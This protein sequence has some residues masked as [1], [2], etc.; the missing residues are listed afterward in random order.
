MG[1]FLCGKLVKLNM[2]EFLISISC[3]FIC[4]VSITSCESDQDKIAKAQQVVNSFIADLNFENFDNIETNYPGFKKVRSFYKLNDFKVKSST[5]N[6]NEVI[7]T[8]ESNR[9]DVL[10][11]LKKE[12]GNY[13]IEKSKGISYYSNS[14]LLRF[15]KKIGCVTQNDYDIEIHTACDGKRD[16][17]NSVVNVIKLVIE[18]KVV[19]F[20]GNVEKNDF[21]VSG[22][23]SYK[24]FSDY[25]IPAYSYNIFLE[26]LNSKGE[27]VFTDKQLYHHEFIG[28]NQTGNIS[29]FKSN[30][31]RFSRVRLKLKIT[32]VSFIE[33]LIADVVT[34][35]N[36]VSDLKK[37]N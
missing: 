6:K 25:N 31:N 10:F 29:I 3:L 2:K 19:A 22:D 23:M 24:N 33:K 5:I 14:N 35:T 12:N 13:V 18:G 32:D 20:N 37:V 11:V 30:S 21:F 34:G 28:A 36:C 1:I 15:C 17:F 26:Y 27:V 8:G 7:I 16:E 9:R 4:F